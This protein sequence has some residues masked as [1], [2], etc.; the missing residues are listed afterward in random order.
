[1]K[2]VACEGV[3]DLIMVLDIKH[4]TAGRFTTDD[5]ASGLALPMISLSLV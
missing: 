5:R 3:S 4:E 1:M 2:P